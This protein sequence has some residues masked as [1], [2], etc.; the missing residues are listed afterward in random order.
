MV[1]IKNLNVKFSK[2]QTEYTLKDISF[3]IS[4]GETV[5]LIGMSGSGKTTLIES[6]LKLN[7]AIVEGE[8]LID[9]KKMDHSRFK[10]D[11]S[12]VFQ[13]YPL[14]EHQ[15]VIKNILNSF[16]G[17]KK[18][19][20]IKY[21]VEKHL[22]KEEI[23][24]L[25]KVDLVKLPKHIKKLY[26]QK[27]I[28]VNKEP[29]WDVK[30]IEAKAKEMDIAK[31]L[32][33]KYPSKLSGGQRQRISILK[34]IIKEPKLV[35]MD[36]PFS[37]L[38][39]IVQSDVIK[40]IKQLKKQGVTFLISSHKTNI[41]DEYSDRF[42]VLKDGKMEYESKDM[43]I[44]KLHPSKYISNLFGGDVYSIDNS[45]LKEIKSNEGVTSIFSNSLDITPTNKNGLEILEKIEK[46]DGTYVYVIN[47]KDREL[48][49]RTRNSIDL[50]EKVRL[51][52]HA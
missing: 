50:S 27:K 6:F 42:I 44:D 7:D 1:I 12:V 25:D 17:T 30:F 26:S 10:N 48:R 14:Y 28:E 29:D 4:D 51:V 45:D 34:A 23:L 20:Y 49:I 15:R 19:Y 21:D 16:E 2:K 32:L 33:V 9:G 52:Y 18:Y 3:T 41:M 8:V 38:D 37:S 39:N 5:S 40:L 46:L 11:I 36:E 13:G 24:E 43:K 31:E 47:Y 35:V 22:T